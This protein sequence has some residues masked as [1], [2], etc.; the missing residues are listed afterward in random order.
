MAE[1]LDFA[2]V[3]TSTHSLS[4]D[5]DEFARLPT[6]RVEAEIMRMLRSIAPDV[7]FFPDDV[8]LAAVALA[9]AA[10]KR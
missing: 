8:A 1:R 7:S 4:L 9:D 6:P 10:T 5:P 2:F 3:G